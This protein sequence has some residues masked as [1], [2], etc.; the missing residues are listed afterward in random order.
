MTDLQG[1]WHG[2]RRLLPWMIDLRRAIH[3]EPELGM[4]EFRTA[5]RMVETLRE[6]DIPCQSGVAGTGVVGLLEGR[7]PGPCVALRADMDALPLDEANDVPYRSTLP[8]R[9][10]ACG[11]DAHCAVQ[12]GA[13]RLL[14]ERRHFAG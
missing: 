8:G 6:L 9:M 14:A 4:E 2:A 5:A 7:A 12:L 13:A 3:Q 1:L 11:H 10:H